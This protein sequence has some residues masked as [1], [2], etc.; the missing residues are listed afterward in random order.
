MLDRKQKSKVGRAAF[1]DEYNEIDIYIEDTAL[2]YQK[3][4][5][6]LMSRLFEGSYKVENVFPLGGRGQVI[7]ACKRDQSSRGRTRLYIID[8]DLFLLSG[9]VEDIS[10]KGLYVLPRYCIENHL[11]CDKSLEYIMDEE[12]PEK[13]LESLRRD[14]NYSGW[15]ESIKTDLIDLFVEY[16]VAKSIAPHIQTVAFGHKK[17]ISDNSG[18]LDK[19]KVKNRIENL[20][21]TVIQHAGNT[22]YDK[23]K[24]KILKL[25]SY[26]ETSLL[27]YVSGKDILMP[28]IMLRL[29]KNIKTNSTN[30]AIKSRISNICQLDS[31][32]GLKRNIYT[33]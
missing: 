11:L 32:E 12:E 27:S 29:R 24:D 31:F 33:D 4:F 22:C 7:D 6:K 2:G 21:A 10:L 13:S 18:E 14:F 17:L 19:I 23:E 20:K 8:G 26:S 9:E 1:F 15:V 25:V 5:S 30:I 28:L 16:G 3:L